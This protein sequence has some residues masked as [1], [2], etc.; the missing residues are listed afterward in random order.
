MTGTLEAVAAEL[1][2][3]V[4]TDPAG[5]KSLAHVLAVVPTRQSGRRLRCALARRLGAMVPPAVKTT[6]SM[7]YDE[8]D[9]TVAGRTDELLAFKAAGKDY[10]FYHNGTL[11]VKLSDL[12]E[13]VQKENSMLFKTFDR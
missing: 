10:H 13:H 7:F 2:A 12:Y 6:A 11:E 9:E 3:K 1:S 5:V 8:N 4:R